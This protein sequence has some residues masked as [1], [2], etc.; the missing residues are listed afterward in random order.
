MKG[1]Q[2]ELPVP[3]GTTPATT[4]GNIPAAPTQSMSERFM[5]KVV[6]EFGS[7]VGELAL[8][9]HQKRLAQ[10]YFMALDAALK[11]AEEKRLKKSEQ[12]RDLVPITW[13]NVNMSLLARNVVSAARIGWDALEKNHVHLVPYK[14]NTTGQY[15]I[16]FLPGYRGLELK[17]NTPLAN[18]LSSPVNW[19]SPPTNSRL[20]RRTTRTN[21]TLI[22]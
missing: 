4:A 14:N 3:A 22:P 1:K 2:Q 19:S 20:S 12:Y 13:Q 15:D 17:R 6:S 5:L 11:L 10:N 8:T 18:R 21:S 16:G 9:E 7:G